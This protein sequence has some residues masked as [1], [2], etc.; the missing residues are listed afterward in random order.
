MGEGPLAANL[1]I[2]RIVLMHVIDGVLDHAGAID[3]DLLQT[4]GRMGSS[5]YSRTQDRFSMD[6]PDRR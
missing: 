6:R 5:L 3:P 1:V 4:I 2:C